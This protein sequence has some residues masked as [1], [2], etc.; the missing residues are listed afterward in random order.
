MKKISIFFLTFITILC[1]LT[2]VNATT[3]FITLGSSTQLKS[4]IAGVSFPYKITMNGKYVYSTDNKKK[5]PQHLKAYRVEN[6]KFVNGGT[7][8]I[9]K[10]GYPNKSITGSIDK[11]YYITQTA[12]WWYLDMTT[13]STNLSNDFKTTGSDT[14]GLRQYVKDLAYAGYTHRSDGVTYQEPKFAINATSGTTMTLDGNYYVSNTI[15]AT[16]AQ[17]ISNYAV[18]LSN[19][20]SG[21]RIL[22]GDGVEMVYSKEFKVKTTDT[23]KVKVP[24]ANLTDTKLEIKVNAVAQGTTQYSAAEYQPS[25]TSMQSVLM[26]DQGSKELSSSLT[27]SIVS[28][29]VTISKIDSVTKKAIAGAKLVLK[30]ANGTVVASWTSTTNSHV[31]H[32]LA[33]GN[34]TIEETEAPS[35]YVLNKNVTKFTISDTKSQVT[36]NIENAPKKSVVNITKI[37]QSTK[38]P[39]A[40]AVLVVKKSN[41]T[42]VAR[43][44]TTTSSYVLTDL[45]N[46]TYTITELS[47]PSGY[48]INTTPVKFTIDDNHL[49]H[50]ITFANAKEVEIPDTAS[51]TSIIAAILGI[52]IIGF[53]LKFIKKNAK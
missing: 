4:F 1:S 13:G 53:G 33:K 30:N 37:D 40:G 32:N 9:L 5:V 44:T 6:S 11:D 7:V 48:T 16:T 3:E 35:G 47:A 51:S 20:P 31:I 49:S 18:T 17:N 24:V 12:L 52:V 2:N 41:G 29:K 38:E 22:F 23:F 50:Q 19:A 45:A 46:D 10:N 43:F 14:Y 26:L 8:Y 36:I 27:L 42:E 28:S 39:L 25:D 21:T 34:Y 15:K